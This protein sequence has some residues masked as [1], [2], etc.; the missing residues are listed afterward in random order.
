MC[1]KIRL[2]KF[3]FKVL[4]I[5]N[6]IKEKFL[7]NITKFQWV[8]FEKS[9]SVYHCFFAAMFLTLAVTRVTADRPQSCVQPP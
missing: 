7:P 8:D 2:F 5:L 9:S 1:R 3:H 6:T 4:I